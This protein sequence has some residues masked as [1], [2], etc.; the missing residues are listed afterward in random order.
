MGGG[1]SGE[2]GG[3]RAEEVRQGYRLGGAKH[4]YIYKSKGR[5]FFLGLCP[6]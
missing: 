5:C 1:G 3:E 6:K 4:M 2:S